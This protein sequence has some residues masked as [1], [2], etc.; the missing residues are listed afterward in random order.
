MPD[1]RKLLAYTL[2][3]VTFIVLLGAGSV[4]RKI[5]NNIWFT[6]AE[7]WIYPVQTILCGALL[8]RFYR[9]YPFSVPQPSWFHHGDRRFSFSPLDFATTISWIGT[10]HDRLQ[11]GQH[12]RQSV[13]I[14][15]A[16][17]H[18]TFPSAGHSG[19]LCRRNLLARF[20][21]SLFDQRKL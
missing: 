13:A 18:S 4:L 6:S 5:S 1:K 12:F 8:I 21:P 9:D 3:M 20:S 10:A 11:S 7:H 16:N 14:L 2:P 19:S 17:H 15:L